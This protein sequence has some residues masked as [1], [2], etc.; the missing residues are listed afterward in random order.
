MEKCLTNPDPPEGTFG[1]LTYHLKIHLLGI[2]PQI[3]RRL[4]VRVDTTLAQLHHILQV[5]I[6]WENNAVTVGTYTVFTSGESSTT[7]GYL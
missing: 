3:F 6:G 7:S 4:A 1:A 5:V 2:S